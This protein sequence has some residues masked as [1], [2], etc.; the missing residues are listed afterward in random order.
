MMK[1][2]N[3]YFF[4]IFVIL[5]EKYDTVF[6]ILDISIIGFFIHENHEN[7]EFSGF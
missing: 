1:M 4:Y 2:Y 3:Y 7:S 5:N 6:I